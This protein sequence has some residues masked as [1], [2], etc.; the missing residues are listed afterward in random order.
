[1]SVSE[2][3]PYGVLERALRSHL[4]H[5]FGDSDR[6]IDDLTTRED[7]TGCLYIGTWQGSPRLVAGVAVDTQRVADVLLVATKGHVRADAAL[8]GRSGPNIGN[9]LL[10]GRLLH[11]AVFALRSA[12]VVALRNEP[13]DARVRRLYQDMGFSRGELLPLDDVSAT[14]MLFEYVEA[15]YQHAAAAGLVTL[16][17]PPLPL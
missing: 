3:V 17:S 7:S 4:L 15:S 8:F 16:A 14:T 11:V 2:Q 9:S 1:M 12:S 6:D 5:A 10:V 13:Y